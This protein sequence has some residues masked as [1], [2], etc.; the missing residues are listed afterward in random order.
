[1]L[2]RAANVNMTF[3][4]YP[5][6]PPAVT[7]LLGE[8]VTSAFVT[9]FDAAEQVKAGKLRALAVASQTRIP[10]LPNVP[11]VAEAGYKDVEVEGGPSS[12]GEIKRLLEAHRVSFRLPPGDERVALDLIEAVIPVEQGDVGIATVRSGDAQLS[13]VDSANPMRNVEFDYAPPCPF[14]TLKVDCAI[15]GA[16][17]S[18]QSQSLS[19]SL[20][21]KLSTYP[22]TFAHQEVICPAGTGGM[23]RGWD[24]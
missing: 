16:L 22:H 11:T 18:E 7:A 21:P 23:W 5:G 19:R 15:T 3:V 6:S 20:P 10:A 17:L 4:P 2:K 9:Y 12:S 8:H 24:G 14:A 1:M 13:A